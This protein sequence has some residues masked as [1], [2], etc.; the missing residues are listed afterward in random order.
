MHFSDHLFI[1]WQL[2]RRGWLVTSQKYRE[3]L[4]NCSVVAGFMALL[5]GCFLPQMGMSTSLI[6][7]L[8]IGQAGVLTMSVGFGYCLQVA[9]DLESIGVTQ[10]H[11]SL[12]LPQ[13]Y[14]VAAYVVTG[15]TQILAILVPMMTIGLF[16]L[17]KHAVFGGSILATISMMTLSSFMFSALVLLVGFYF[18]FDFLINHVWARLFG[19]LTAFGCFFNTFDSIVPHAPHIAL[20]MRCDPMMYPIEGLRRAL[21][22]GESS[23]SFT[24]C[25]GYS[26]FFC[27]FFL[28]GLHFLFRKRFQVSGRMKG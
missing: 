19:I 3:H 4:I 17:R 16:I 11:C 7:P 5:Y 6:V 1:W 21:L 27:L 2:V 26:F 10:Y 13:C 25:V 23:L 15:A 18:S 22:G 20:V 24:T 12:P 9:D 28:V 14:V 8:F